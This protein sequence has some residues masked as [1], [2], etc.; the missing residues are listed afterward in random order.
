VCP[1]PYQ[2]CPCGLLLLFLC[3][4]AS[5]YFSCYLFLGDGAELWSLPRSWQWQLWTPA[6]IFPWI[7]LA[8]AR[9]AWVLGFRCGC[10]AEAHVSPHPHWVC[11]WSHS[12]MR[13]FCLHWH[14]AADLKLMWTKG[15]DKLDVGVTEDSH[16]VPWYKFSMGSQ[17][18]R[19]H[20]EGKAD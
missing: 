17:G 19:K 12:F 6:G 13:Y 8:V 7:A 15:H 10:G 1:Q 14:T 9:A 11:P 16:K 20:R 2:V 3:V 5:A 4:H 18:P